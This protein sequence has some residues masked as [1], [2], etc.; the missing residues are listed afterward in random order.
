M[1]KTCGCGL[2]LGLASHVQQLLFPKDSP[3]CGGCSI[4]TKNRMAQGLGGD[5]FDFIPLPDGC[6]GIMIGDV[7]GHGLEASVVMSLLYGFVHH[8][9]GDGITV[10]IDLVRRVNDFLLTFADRSRHFDHYFSSTM[11]FGVLD[12]KTLEMHYVNAG[13]PMPMARRGQEIFTFPATAPPVGFFKSPE[14]RMRSF[15]FEVGDRLLLYTD[16]ITETANAEGVLFSRERLQEVLREGDHNHLEFLDR[17]FSELGA[18]GLNEEP[19]DDCTAIV[20]DFNG[21]GGT[22][23]AVRLDEVPS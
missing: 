13:H 18:F 20:I 23:S 10:P 3:L 11:F 5:Y 9:A 15:R 6:Q 1:R 22:S 21:T 14:M 2:D 19:Q 16:G 17:I 7:T 8:C 4:G 12:P